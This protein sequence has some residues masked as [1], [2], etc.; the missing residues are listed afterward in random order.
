MPEPGKSQS[1]RGLFGK[2]PNLWLDPD[3][4]ETLPNHYRVP[5]WRPD[6]G[7][8]CWDWETLFLVWYYRKGCHFD[9]EPQ[10]GLWLSSQPTKRQSTLARQSPGE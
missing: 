1:G 6:Q 5:V 2:S 3:A 10:F 4:M 7:Q 8:C 9:V